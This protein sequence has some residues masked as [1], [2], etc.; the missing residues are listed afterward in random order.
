MEETCSVGLISQHCA[1]R[2]RGR[3][4]YLFQG[5]HRPLSKGA[6]WRQYGSG[7]HSVTEL[8]PVFPHGSRTVPGMAAQGGLVEQLKVHLG[9]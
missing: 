6:T 2:A 8:T 5:F 3:C 4:S 9:P 1:A 7:R